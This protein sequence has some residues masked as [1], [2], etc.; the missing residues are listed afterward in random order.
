M[1]KTTLLASGVLAVSTLFA[2]NAVEQHQTTI[3]YPSSFAISPSVAE[4]SEKFQ[5]NE[6]IGNDER[7]ES[8]D[9]KNRIPM[10]FEHTG[11]DGPEWGNDPATMQT[12][13]GNRTPATTLTDWAGQSGGGYPPD[14]SGS[15]GPN[16]YIQAVNA[17][18]VKIFNKTSGAQLALFNLGTLWS[19]AVGNL[20]DPIV[21]YDKTADRWFLAQFGSGNKIY[22]AVSKT[23]D[24]TGQ[25]S[26]YTYTASSFP[27]YL[28]FSI[29][30]DGYYMTA[31][32]SPRTVWVFDRAAMIAG[33]ATARMAS[34][35]WTA[36]GVGSQG[37]SFF[38]PLTGDADGT[39]PTSGPCPLVYPVD[40]G[41]GASADGIYL[42][43][44][45]TNWSGS[46][47]VT[48]STGTLIS[49]STH[50]MSYSSGWLDIS[51]PGTSQKLDGIGGV[52]MFRAQWRKW[53]GYNT[54]LVTFPVKI[55]TTQRSF[56]WVELRQTG[57]TWTKY[58][59]S[60]YTPD[61]RSRWVSS[62]AMNDN[63]DIGVTYA[64][65]S[66]NA[67]DYAS[68]A[69]T[70]RC[71]N[72]ALNQLTVAEVV[73]TGGTGNSAQVGIERFGDYGQ[74]AIDPSSGTKFWATQEYIGSGQPRT[75]I[76][77]FQ[78]G[79]PTG[80]GENGED[81]SSYNVYQNGNII[82][83]EGSG[84]ISNENTQVDL[85]D[86]NGREV[87][88]QVVKPISNSIKTTIN[89]TGLS[90]GVYFV[91]IGNNDYQKVIKLLLK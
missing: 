34:T 42:K 40:N 46:G 53:T 75:R 64:R 20:G 16:H 12:K 3:I 57:S 69:Y 14:P 65:A 81:I 13:M 86:I 51:Q 89:T 37:A 21:L 43:E 23:A 30:H 71:K 39:L 36:T 25:Y 88:N 5:V 82:N 1:K 78:L 29:W 32:M 91:R 17:T 31:N 19:P 54:L 62:M 76:W 70:G 26:T 85:F 68:C 60:V 90:T 7:K 35:T 63:G 6:N 18:P 22:I 48:V 84:L 80:I 56:K 9:R 52:A 87:N 41:W 24:P 45:T 79:C 50:D 67:G 44:I 4:L 66:A 58:Q 8:E 61:S 28:K 2:Q 49:T 33:S 15:V 72:D 83:V 74:T 11:E 38:C 27:D 10:K 73:V 55:S 77:S 47:S 59:E